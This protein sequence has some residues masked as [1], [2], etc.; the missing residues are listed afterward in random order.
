[1][2]K[3]TGAMPVITATVLV[4]LVTWSIGELGQWVL[5]NIGR[6]QATYNL[7]TSWLEAHEILV[8]GP[9]NERFDATWIVGPLRAAA[10]TAREALGFLMLAF[11]FVILGM[12]EVF[13]MPARLRELQVGG[14]RWDPAATGAIVAAKFRRYM[15]VRAV[16]SVLTGAATAG[17]AAMIG[18]EKPLAWGVLTFA[19]N[20]LPF[21]G[22][23]VVVVLITAFTAAQFGTW[24]A[25]LLMLAGATTA[26]FIIGS[27]LEP[28]LAGAAL[29]M[30]PFIVLFAV[31]F[32]G[33]LWGIPGAFLGVPIVVLLLTICA[34]FPGTRWMAVLLAGSG[35]ALLADER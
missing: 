22:G 31:F 8:V 7:S 17:I 23:L 5:A 28:I 9:L 27:Y 19:L 26:Q 35:S 29:S 20:F 30:S 6:F 34:Q 4:L 32:W 3:L 24:Q 12:A 21:I 11:V 1:M 15:G 14:A 2:I 25:P 13:Q 18:V 10:G 33:L 16:A